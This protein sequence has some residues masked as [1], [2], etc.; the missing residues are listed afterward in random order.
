[1][2]YACFI[3]LNS[4]ANSVN[5]GQ[6]PRKLTFTNTLDPDEMLL[7]MVSRQGCA[8]CQHKHTLYRWMIIYG[9]NK[10]IYK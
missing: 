4:R 7:N 10:I 6:T 3:I 2:P 5:P 9:Q 8:I 1:M